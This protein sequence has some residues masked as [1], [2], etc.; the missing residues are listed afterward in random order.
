MDLVEVAPDADP[1]VCKIVDYKKV[2]YKQKRKAREGR[3][4]Q[5]HVE[6]KEVKM[7]PTIGVHD[8]EFKIRHIRQFVEQ[9]HKAKVTV[10]FKG[11]EV[12]HM[13]LG[14]KLLEKVVAELDSAVEVEAGPLRQGRSIALILAGK[15][16]HDRTE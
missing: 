16:E 15:K 11:R 2:I 1:P 5:R 13:D 10:T 7:R 12:V 3:K 6:L 8:Y 9:G 4:K 14:Y